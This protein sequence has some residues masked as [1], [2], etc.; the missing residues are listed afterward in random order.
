MIALLRHGTL[1]R[2]EGG[3]MEF[4][5]LAAEFKSAF[6]NSVHWSIRLWID[7]LHEGG[8][9]KRFQF[10]TDSHGTQ[11]LNLRAIQGHSGENLVDPSLLDNVLVPDTSFEFIYHVECYFNMHPMI[12]SGLIAEGKIVVENG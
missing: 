6:P 5:R 3:A 12:G 1:P 8:G 2:D 10:C 11:F 9:Q 4:W 7:H